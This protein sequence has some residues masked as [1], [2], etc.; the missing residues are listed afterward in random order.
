[1]KEYCMIGRD[2]G[3]VICAENAQEAKELAEK[4]TNAQNCTLVLNL[5]I[6]SI[7]ISYHFL[8]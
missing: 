1:M 2:I 5:N 7:I 8:F 4:N 3:I 6:N